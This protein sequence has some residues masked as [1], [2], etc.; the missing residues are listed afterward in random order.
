MK[1]AYV[2]ATM[3]VGQDGVTRCVYRMIDAAVAHG[4]DVIALTSAVPEGEPPVP[5]FSVPSFAIPMHKAYRMAYPGTQSVARH[6]DVIR[7][8]IIHV[9]SP[10]TLGYAAMRYAKESHIPVVAT[11]HTHFPTY[12]RYYGLG[13]FEELAWTL[14]RR[15]YKG[16]DRT[17]VPARP[18]LEELREH[19]LNRLQ[20]IPNGVDN[21][22]FNPTR[23][24]RAWRSQFG[25]DDR[26]I[27]L[28][29]SRLVWEKDLRV[30]SDAYRLLVEGGS[31]FH[32]VIVG[33]GHAREELRH[34]MPGAHFLGYQS[35]IALAEAYAS[36]DIFVFPST[37]ETFGLVTL[38]AMA[39]GIAPV[40]AAIGGAVELITD[41][42]T[43]L[44]AA[45]FSPGELAEGVRRLLDDPVMRRTISS[46]AATHAATYAWDRVLLRMFDAYVDVIDTFAATR[47]HAAHASRRGKLL[48]RMAR[49]S[50]A[51]R[52]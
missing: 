47:A 1:I 52:D 27:V 16:I 45:P 36:S 19:G 12:P 28:F 25:D 8:D 42:V 3:T 2:N 39:S 17:F 37:T 35:G 48:P 18:I 5:M 23:R 32:M 43:G 10:C 51:G 29:V 4:H 9:N 6:L 30:L 34:L 50:S 41:G 13:G 24:S 21:A 44:F 40:A 31:T 14:T 33:D 46:T 49:A 38:E 22:L 26:P 11:Y 7:P 15:Y 20:Y